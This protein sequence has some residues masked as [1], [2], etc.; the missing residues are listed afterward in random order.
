MVS[1]A[2]L[3]YFPASSFAGPFFSNDLFV[4][5]CTLIVIYIMQHKD[6]SLFLFII[7]SNLLVVG[8][9]APVIETVELLNMVYVVLSLSTLQSVWMQNVPDELF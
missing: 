4:F 2:D 7:Y 5:V 6:K 9:I 1:G 3:T 8:F